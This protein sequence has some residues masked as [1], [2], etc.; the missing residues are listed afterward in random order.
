MSHESHAAINSVIG[1]LGSPR[2]ADFPQ[3]QIERRQVMAAGDLDTI[4]RVARML[5]GVADIHGVSIAHPAAVKL[6]QSGYA[7]DLFHMVAALS[8]FDAGLECLTPVLM[9][10]EFVR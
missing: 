5:K 6:E 9:L 7:G 1:M 4:I 8:P 10:K 2:G 3:W